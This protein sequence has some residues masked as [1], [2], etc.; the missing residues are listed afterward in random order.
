MTLH[1]VGRRF[2]VAFA[3]SL[4]TTADVAAVQIT[5]NLVQS[6]SNLTL[7]GDY[8]G[9]D[10]APVNPFSPQ[11]HPDF[12]TAGT[13]DGDPSH[14][15]NRT[16]LTGT[17]T[18]DVDNVMAPT[19]IQILSANMDAN[20]T[21]VWLPEP[22]P[23]DGT[24]SEGTDPH[25][26]EPA[27]VGVKI[28]A[29]FGVPG[30]CDLAYAAFRD[31]SYNLETADP[32]TLTPV[33]E[34]VNTQ[35]EFSSITQI[36]SY[37][38]GF[39]EYWADPFLINERNRDSVAGD[40]APNQHNVDASTDPDTFTPI[41]N[42]PK[43]TYVVSGNLVTLTIPVEINIDNPGDLSQYIDGQL[44]ATFE[45]PENSDGDYNEDGVVNAADYVAWRKTPASFG[46][47]PG[48][49][50]AWRETF[51]ELSAGSGGAV[52]E[53]AAAISGMISLT[54]FFIVRGRRSR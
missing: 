54:A 51:G 32:E 19:T 34:P 16:T 12:P 11:D 37:H 53:P 31:L 9:T 26:A 14:P 8:L 44:L 22:Q 15:S 5:L 25:P 46:G 52:P 3:L 33:V 42:A 2:V 35:G 1:A 48:G 47:E 36:L 27:D 40:G 43:S 45:I 41:P 18:V 49:Y 28:I 29:D 13:T 10:D 24:E 30:C 4:W 23:D 50:N 21:G 17:I 20:I 39:F 38:T 7:N 6:Q